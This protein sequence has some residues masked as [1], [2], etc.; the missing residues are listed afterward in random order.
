[1]MNPDEVVM[2]GYLSRLFVIVF[3]G[4]AVAAVTFSLYWYLR[5]RVAFYHKEHKEH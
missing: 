1:M 5:R 2:L 4:F 3:E